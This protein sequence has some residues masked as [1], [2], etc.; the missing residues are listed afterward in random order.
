MGNNLNTR[1]V[2]E[3]YGISMY[4]V[5]YAISTKRLKAVKWGHIYVI[6][7]EDL[8]ERWPIIRRGRRRKGE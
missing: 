6:K 2:A 3:R 7:E 1:Q 4:Q 8:P 5:H